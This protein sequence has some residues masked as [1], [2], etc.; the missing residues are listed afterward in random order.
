VAGGPPS[1]SGHS[2][3]VW[4]MSTSLNSI[5]NTCLSQLKRVDLTSP[6]IP[7]TT[8]KLS[9]IEDRGQTDRVLTLTYDIQ[10]QSLRA[11]VVTYTRAKDQGQTSVGSKDRVE[12]DR[13]TDG[14]DCN[15][16][17]ANAVGN[18]MMY[19][20][21]LQIC[22][23]VFLCFRCLHL[24]AKWNCRWIRRLL[25]LLYEVDEFRIHILIPFSYS[26]TWDY[27]PKIDAGVTICLSLLYY[28]LF[29]EL[30]TGWAKKVVVYYFAHPVRICGV[31]I[32][33]K[34]QQKS[35]I[36]LLPLFSNVGND[37]HLRKHS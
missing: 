25:S 8:R 9:S 5:A 36:R 33:N 11:I 35:S 4:S 24:V 3:D 31:T 15:T 23:Y 7:E 37:R 19:L 14:G 17:C 27:W 32:K 12:T 29:C 34:M 6:N 10:F 22:R 16:Y 2:S 21:L 18:Y 26:L 28:V 13:R 30:C 20:V 1:G